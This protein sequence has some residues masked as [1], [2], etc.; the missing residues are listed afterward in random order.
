[1]QREFYEDAT[2]GQVTAQLKATDQFSILSD[3]FFGHCCLLTYSG[4]FAEEC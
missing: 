4:A 1:M 2:Q 3:K